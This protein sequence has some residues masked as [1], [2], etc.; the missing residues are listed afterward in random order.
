MR[1]LCNGTTGR[2]RGC[3]TWAVLSIGLDRTSSTF[4]GWTRVPACFW[5]QQ[6]L[7]NLCEHLELIMN[8][9]EF[10]VRSYDMDMWNILWT[11]VNS[12]FNLFKFYTCVDSICDLCVIFYGVTPPSKREQCTHRK[13]ENMFIVNTKQWKQLNLCSSHTKSLCK[14]GRGLSVAPECLAW[15][16][17]PQQS[18]Q[19]FLTPRRGVPG[20]ARV[21]GMT[22]GAHQLRQAFL[23]H[24]REG[25]GHAKS[26]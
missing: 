8:F 10:D 19:T 13:S 4:S 3:T 20:H 9:C 1:M 23:E 17:A 15:L 22:V 6:T 24:R 5:S 26:G 14:L 2:L 25:L 21:F 12:I 11:C 16:L 18:R 7:K